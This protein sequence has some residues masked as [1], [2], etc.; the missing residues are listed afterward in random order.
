[1]ITLVP[2]VLEP[3]RPTANYVMTT[4]PSN[5]MAPANALLQAILT[6]TLA[7]ATYVTSLAQPA[8]ELLTTIA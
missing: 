2:D 8:L 7:D 1:M 5:L 3:Y 6:Q 4:L